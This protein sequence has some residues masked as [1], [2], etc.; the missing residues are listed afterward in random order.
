MAGHRCQGYACAMASTTDTIIDLR[1]DTVTKPTLAMRR[2]MAEAVVGDDVLGDDPT[3]IAL[4]DRVA[5]MFG[6]ERAVYV[7]SGTMANQTAIR[8]VCESGDEIICHRDSHIIHY[9]TGAPAAISGVMIQTLDGALGQFEASQIKGAMRAASSHFACSK[10]LLIEN[11][12]NRNGGAIWPIQKIA[13]VTSE[14]RKHGLWCHLDGARIWNAS[15]ATGVSLRE[16]A[17][18]FDSISCCFSKGLGAPVGSAVLGPEKFITRV[19]RFRKMLGGTMRQS[20]IL[21]AACLHALDHHIERLAEDHAKAKKLAELLGN[22]KGLEIVFPIQSNM[23]FVKWNQ[24][25][26]AS[27]VV[28]RVREHGLVCMAS[29]ERLMRLVM[30]LD[31]PADAVER[32]ATTLASA[33]KAA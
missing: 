9:E 29:G 25:P 3:V 19:H 33:I 21:A 6:K 26:M 27:D 20:G 32:I 30:H 17:Q 23:V 28:V 5:H 11:T 2:A 7:P 22:E 18:H 15:V 1:S 31:V 14:A 24:G 16:Y 13:E 8:A 4:Q 12:H 10:M